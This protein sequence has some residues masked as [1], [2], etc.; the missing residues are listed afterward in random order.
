MPVKIKRREIPDTSI[1]PDHIHPV[2][3]RVYAARSI[4]S[5]HELDYSLQGILPWNDLLGMDQAVTLLSDAIVNNKRILIVGDFD[6]DGAT[7]SAIAI[8]GLTAMG[9]SKVNYLVPNRFEYGYGLSPEIVNVAKV[10]KPDLLITVD[11]GIASTDGVALA[12]SIGIDVLITDHHLPGHS[13]PDANAIVN[14]NQSGD[15]FASKALA[16]VGVIFY[17]LIALRAHLRESGWFENHPIAEPNLGELLDLVALGTIADVV[18]LDRNNRILVSQGL[19]RIRK[20]L[21]C[22]GLKALLES[23]RRS[24]NQITAQ[25]LAFAVAPRLNAA[26]RIDDMSLGI[27]CLLADDPGQARQHAR[28]LEALNQE[29]RQIQ[30]EM[31]AQ[32]L[33]DLAM[34]ELQDLDRLPNGLCLFNENWHQGVIGILAA[35]IKDHLSRPVIVFALDKDGFIKGSARSVHGLHIRDVLDTMAN[36]HPELINKFGGHAMA[37]GLTI[38]KDD[39]DRFSHLFDE[40]AGEFTEADPEANLISDGPLEADEISMELARLIREGGP[41][42]QGFPEPVF[43]GEFELVTTRIVG[44][45]HLKLQLRDRENRRQMEAI[46]FNTTDAD[47]PMDCDRV[48]ALYRLDINEFAGRKKLQLLIEHIEPSTSEN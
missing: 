25:D 40:I 9:A 1:L 17:V 11:N 2:L 12:R 36:R 42:G 7:S 15:R 44:E 27:E 32:A 34:R 16:G 35:R 5:A 28:Q 38:R 29:R 30:A 24:L 31:H 18:P 47:W 10:M 14:P 46:A 39:L 8:K 33:D 37:A 21:C 6:A 19:A 23:A 48:R 3:R 26:G 20:G 43:D 13:L 4:K 45:K 41:W 22:A